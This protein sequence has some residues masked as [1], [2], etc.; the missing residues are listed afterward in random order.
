MDQQFP[1]QVAA[2]ADFCAWLDQAAPGDILEYHRGFL[3]LDCAASVSPLRT[4]Q[5]HRLVALAEHAARAADQGFA[6]LVQRRL[7]PDTYSYLAIARRRSKR[8]RAAQL[9]MTEVA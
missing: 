9:I 4:E 1:A 7:G 5:R 3:A 6:H 8:A 2:E